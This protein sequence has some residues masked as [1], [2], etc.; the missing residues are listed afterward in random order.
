MMIEVFNYKA[1]FK[2]SWYRLLC[3]SFVL[4]QFYSAIVT[5]TSHGRS[6]GPVLYSPFTIDHSL[7]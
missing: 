1:S 2:I 4:Q 3:H 5:V 7:L 6:E